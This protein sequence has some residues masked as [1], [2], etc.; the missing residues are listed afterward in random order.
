M[1]YSSQEGAVPS[2]G[3]HP[4]S[5]WGAG[6]VLAM[7]LVL[8]G[9]GS[10]PQ[11]ESPRTAN[12]RAPSA[13]GRV[14]V[15]APTPTP[16]ED[17]V[18]SPQPVTPADKPQ[19][20]QGA[21]GVA[22]EAPSTSE[23]E[24]DQAEETLSASK[25]L[26]VQ[27]LMLRAQLQ[28]EQEKLAD[29]IATYE[30]A[31]AVV[32]E[33]SFVLLRLGQAYLDASKPE[34]ALEMGLRAEKASPDEPDVHGLIAQAHASL[35]NFEE[36]LV[37]ARKEVRLNPKAIG[38]YSRIAEYA[39]RLGDNETVIDALQRLTYLDGRNAVQY[40]FSL[41]GVLAASGRL[42]EAVEA[43]REVL[44]QFP[45]AVETLESI[46]DLLRRMGRPEEAIESYR[47]ALESG[48]L[49][50]NA[51]R[52]IRFRLAEVL[53]QRR[54]YAEAYAEYQRI[55]DANPREPRAWSAQIEILI[56]QKQ[57]EQAIDEIRQ[58]LSQYPF[59]IRVA[60][61]NPVCQLR[62]DRN[63][64]AARAVVSILDT[65]INNE[66]AGPVE[67]ALV[68]ERLLRNDLIEAVVESGTDAP[69]GE[70][71]L[72]IQNSTPSSLLIPAALLALER[73]LG[74]AAAQA[75]QTRILTERLCATMDTSADAEGKTLR[76][77]ESLL[78]LNFLME[79]PD[80]LAD[81]LLFQPGESV[82]A[83]DW[84]FW[85]ERLSLLI[86]ERDVSGE[87]STLPNVDALRARMEEYVQRLPDSLA[88]RLAILGI[89]PDADRD[90]VCQSLMTWLNEKISDA[91]Q[92][93]SE[94]AVSTIL[95]GDLFSTFT[96]DS[97]SQFLLLTLSR[98]EA[99]FPDNA[100]YGYAQGLVMAARMDAA[101]A[102]AKL[103]SVAEPLPTD[104]PWYMPVQ[105]RLAWVYDRDG[106]VEE[107]GDL[108]NR[109]LEID[110]TDPEI[111]RHLTLVYD[112]LDRLDKVEEHANRVIA[113]LPDD[114]ESYNMLGYT[115]A[116][117]DT[118]LDTALELIERALAIAP[119]DGNITD[120]LGWVY[121]RMGLY[122]RAVETLEKALEL[123]GEDH[124]VILDHLGDAYAKTGRGDEAATYWK[125]AL[126]AGPDYPYDFTDEFQRDVRE[127]LQDAGDL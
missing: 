1:R 96:S 113:L 34:K 75:A 30:E 101:G 87:L 77:R 29:A 55:R 31:V 49:S 59:D 119:D 18:E 104:D 78:T 122:D 58:Y 109:L 39:S 84:D 9:C 120:S 117:R 118:K 60:L 111:H 44:E 56:E 40:R 43:Y 37:E 95:S 71:L 106:R 90:P 7:V 45:D 123:V 83:E 72:Q 63:G 33:S 26:D 91:D 42:E 22:Q 6:F 61:L 107:A 76:A 12:D 47:Q 124:P 79:S 88:V 62:L 64:E 11:Q 2:L 73:Q 46:A 126:E 70:R 67:Y 38:G 112:K 27:R 50:D 86:H 116:T 16:Q 127:K 97:Q 32:P 28:L 51:A 48:T 98:A 114:P 81:T 8:G 105:K 20:D 54:A 17:T 19:P 103:E 94:R 100:L 14:V 57:Y 41:A 23:S 110:T 102:A 3:R 69:L 25:Q 10:S 24:P 15:E 125:R 89:T 115:Y 4:I 108:L 121:Y 36:A 74:R 99:A 13:T 21:P 66:K 35:K 85:F 65:L 92:D 93:R 53:R 80:V 52:G 82:R 5:R 68:G